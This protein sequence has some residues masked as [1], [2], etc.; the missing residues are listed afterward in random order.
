MVFA[1]Y[2]WMF[3]INLIEKSDW[4]SNQEKGKKHSKEKSKELELSISW[5]RIYIG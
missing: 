3:Q 4:K 1:I 5:Y 2:A